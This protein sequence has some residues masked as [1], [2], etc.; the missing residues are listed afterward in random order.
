VRRHPAARSADPDDRAVEDA[1]RAVDGPGT[2]LPAGIRD[3]VGAALG[4]DFGRVRVHAGRRAASSATMIGARAYTVGNQIAFAPGEYAPQTDTGRWLIAHELTHVAQQRSPTGRGTSAAPLPA[5]FMVQRQDVAP[6]APAALLTEPQIQAAITYNAARFGDPFTI[7]TI[8]ELIGIA[9]YPAVSDRDL[10]L[11]VAAWQDSH[12]PLTVDGKIGAATTRTMAEALGAAGNAALRDQV[13]VDHTVT[14]SA[15]APVV[16][17]VPSPAAWGVFTLNASLN[18]TLR[19][20]WIIQ[21]LRNTWNEALCGGVANP[22]PPTLHYWEAWWVTD[23]GAVRV[24]TSLTTPPTHAAPAV[25]HDVWQRGL[26]PGTS[27]TFTMTGRLFTTLTLPAGFAI[28]AVPDAGDLPSTAAAP[29]ADA[30]GTVQGRRS[31]SGRWN[32]CPGVPNFHTA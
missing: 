19:R 11:G 8:R 18:T 22:N 10:A 17:N 27:G 4:H 23:A 15:D 12:P 24:P 31:A 28:H 30:L 29:A 9:K 26:A 16:R 25:A 32:G 7:A 3:T 5:P 21:E 20:G 6:A 2:P 1:V 13:R 14:A